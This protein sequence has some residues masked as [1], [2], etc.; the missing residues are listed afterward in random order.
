MSLLEL[1]DILNDLTGK[2]SA[3]T[4]DEWRPSDQK[5]YISDI[6][7][8]QSELGWKA[9]VTPKEGVGMLVKWMEENKEQLG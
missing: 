6:T 5:V 9:E 7:K 1:L 4:F 2:R 8:A 3:I